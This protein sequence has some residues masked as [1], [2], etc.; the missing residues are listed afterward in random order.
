MQIFQAW[1]IL[2]FIYLVCTKSKV[3]TKQQALKMTLL[4]GPI[5]WVFMPLIYWTERYVE[6]RNKNRAG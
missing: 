2:G 1:G 5:A 6:R 3:T 4:G